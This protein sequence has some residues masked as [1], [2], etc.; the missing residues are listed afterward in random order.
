MPT[1]TEILAGVTA[2]ATQAI[3]AAIAWHV[4][5]AAVL[6]ALALGWRPSQRTAGALLA[7]PV[8]SVAVAAL[9]SGNPFN[10]IVCAAAAVAMVALALRGA[11]EPVSRGPWWLW[12]VGAALL[13]YGWVYPH[14]LEARALENPTI[15]LY[16]APFGLLPCPTLSV[17]IGLALLGGGVGLR[18]FRLALAGFG[19]FYGLFGVLRLGVLLDVGL[20]AGALVLAATALPGSERLFAWPVSRLTSGH[21]RQPQR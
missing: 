3:A 17:V 8:A 2:L 12:T 5:L 11:R 21:G 6:V 10:G 1:V 20:L 18:G 16:A 19:V 13:A 14:F 15:Y 4:V 7:L 9:A